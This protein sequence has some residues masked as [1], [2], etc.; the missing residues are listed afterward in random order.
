MATRDIYLSENNIDFL[1]RDVCDQVSRKYNFDLNSSSKY[2]KSFSGMMDKVYQNCDSNISGNL[3]SLNRLTTQ[4]ISNYF[5]DQLSKKK[6][7]VNNLMD[8]PM[9]VSSNVSEKEIGNRLDNLMNQR[10]DLNDN[11]KPKTILPLQTMSLQD[12]ESVKGE[13][14]KKYNELLASR[15][16][17]LKQ[18]SNNPLPNPPPQAQPQMQKSNINI[19]VKNNDDF[20][21]LPFTI[22]D[23]FSDQS[24]NIGQPIYI[25]TDQLNDTTGEK[26]NFKYEDLQKKRNTEIQEFLNY[27]QT[28]ENSSIIHNPQE[29]REGLL[30]S[31]QSSNQ[32]QENFE[33][34]QKSQIVSDY[35]GE[36]TGIDHINSMRNPVSI[37]RSEVFSTISSSGSGSDSGSGSGSDSSSMKKTNFRNANIQ[38]N[39]V[40]DFLD[41][42]NQLYDFLLSQLKISEREY[43]D[44]PYYFVVSSEDRQWE[45]NAEN[46]YNFLVNFRPS[47]SQLG[48]GIDTLYKNVVSVEVIKV[49]FPHDRLSVPFDNRI[50]LDLQS[51]P[52][53]IMDIDELDG[54]FKGSNNTLNE[55]FALLLFDKAYDSEVLTN[56]QIIN[57]LTTPTDNIYKRFDRQFK[58][59]FMSFCPFLFEKKKYPNTPL[60]SLNRMTIRF[61]RPDGQLISVDQD[62]LEIE[63]ISVEGIN[64]QEL[65]KTTG[66]PRSIAGQYIKI[67]TKNYFS[68]RTFRIGDLIKIKN[69]KLKPTTTDSDVIN[70]VEYINRKQGHIIINLDN[71]VSTIDETEDPGATGTPYVNDSNEGYINNIYISPA[72]EIDFKTGSLNIATYNAE[73]PE[74]SDMDTINGQLAYGSLINSSMQVHITFKIVTREDKTTSVIKPINV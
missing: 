65:K 22:N 70:F 42:K 68:N 32:I 23:D 55:A 67:T 8:R 64:D 25:N 35:L 48:V 44:V 5:F 15:T 6:S 54:V 21:I 73:A 38:D 37:N 13:T 74:A 24:S 72:G 28:K 19:V 18:S 56:D 40:P 39:N 29:I 11:N 71:E 31:S 20:N 27:Q 34:N 51:Y 41:N 9:K 50:Y 69:C 36:R 43:Q 14:N 46:R 62:N 66:F 17:I 4:K 30:S 3:S 57:S 61:Y 53:L 58:R 47:D 1:Y 33:S 63:N 7:N 49:I 52:F 45:N 59:G 2:K 12:L 26:V 10:M 16:E 60:A